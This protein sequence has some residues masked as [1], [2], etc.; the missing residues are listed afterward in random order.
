MTQKGKK[1]IYD[2]KTGA[3]DLEMEASADEFS[4]EYTESLDDVSST[5]EESDSSIEVMGL[6]LN[7]LS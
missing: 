5:I 1:I 4:S 3:H 7:D 2:M 6:I